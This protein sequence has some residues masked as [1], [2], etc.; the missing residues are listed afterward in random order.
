MSIMN[1]R[2]PF[3]QQVEAIRYRIDACS[4]IKKVKSLI[5]QFGIMPVNK[6]VHWGEWLLTNFAAII[7]QKSNPCLETIIADFRSAIDELQK[8]N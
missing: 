2:R 4:G 5:F 3:G 1:P 8:P 7:V 6:G